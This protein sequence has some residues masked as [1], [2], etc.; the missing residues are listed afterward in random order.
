MTSMAFS[1]RSAGGTPALRSPPA[2]TGVKRAI[3]SG[4]HDHDVAQYP[5]A[6]A[7]ATYSGARHCVMTWRVGL[8]VD[9]LVLAP[10]W[11]AGIAPPIWNRALHMACPR[12]TAR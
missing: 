12:S 8:H 3:F 11:H 5:G 9:C 10:I 6:H 4:S 2:G 7:I 1:R